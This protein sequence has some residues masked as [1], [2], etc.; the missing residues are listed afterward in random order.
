[1]ARKSAWCQVTAEKDG[2]PFTITLTMPRERAVSLATVL[3]AVAETHAAS[4]KEAEHLRRIAREIRVAARR[5][6]R[7]RN[8]RP[9]RPSSR[10]RSDSDMQHVLHGGPPY[11]VLSE[12]DMATVYPLLEA[13]GWPNREIAGRLHITTRTVNRWRRDERI[14]KER[15]N[16]PTEAPG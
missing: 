7:R 9:V 16:A 5:F 4:V 12:R 14:R 13:Y 6:R 2:G 10:Y 15:D 1:M 8:N 11:P 3:Q